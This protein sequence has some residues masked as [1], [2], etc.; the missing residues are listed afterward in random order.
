MN[1]AGTSTGTVVALTISIDTRVWPTQ[2]VKYGGPGVGTTCEHWRP[3]IREEFKWNSN[4]TM[5]QFC[6]KYGEHLTQAE[7]GAEL[8]WETIKS[9]AGC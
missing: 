2:A 5:R 3:V 7:P 4:R 1:Q 6:P 8:A 9:L